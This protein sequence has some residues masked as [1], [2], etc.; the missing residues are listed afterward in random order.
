LFRSEVEH[1]LDLA[2]ARNIGISPD[3]Q[4]VAYVGRGS[5]GLQVFV[6]RLNSFTATAIP[7][8]EGAALGP[9]FSPDGKAL[10]YVT[11]AGTPDNR[12]SLNGVQAVRVATN[13]AC[14]TLE[15]RQQG[16]VVSTFRGLEL[17][18]PSGGTG[19]VLGALGF[20]GV[21]TMLP[22]GSVIALSDVGGRPAQALNDATG[23]RGT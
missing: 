3:G 20:P 12:V 1:H 14:C 15:W 11:Q 18:P 19:R 17:I 7:G 9:V 22:D 16:L 10:A 13:V 2:F 23:K 8:T 4:T 21:A 5:G 6:R